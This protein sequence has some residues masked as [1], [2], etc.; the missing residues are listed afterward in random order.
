[1]EVTSGAT[2][3]R[4]MN[5]LNCNK[6]PKLASAAGWNGAPPVEGV[7][8]GSVA[9]GLGKRLGNAFRLRT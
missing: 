7:G 9:N 5:H 8:G 1:M 6:R 4:K 2:V 3:Y